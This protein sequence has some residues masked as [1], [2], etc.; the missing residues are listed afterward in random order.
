ME[1]AKQQLFRCGS[2]KDIYYCSKPCQLAD[3]KGGHKLEC[4]LY[5]EWVASMGNNTQN[6]DDLSLITRTMLALAKDDKEGCTLVEDW[7]GARFST[8]PAA[9]A[10]GAVPCP[11]SCGRAHWESMDSDV[12]IWESEEAEAETGQGVGEG[13]GQGQEDKAQRLRIATA[14]AD[15]LKGVRTVTPEEAVLAMK[16]FSAN[17]FSI[18]NEMLTGYAAGVFPWAAVLNH[19]CAPNCVV[20]FAFS[21]KPEPPLLQLIAAA[22]IRPGDELCH[23]YVDLTLATPNRGVQLKQ[24]YGIDRCMCMRCMGGALAPWPRAGKDTLSTHIDPF[25]F[26]GDGDGYGDGDGD[27]DGDVDA[28]VDVDGDVDGDGGDRARTRRKRPKV[29]LPIDDFYDIQPW[30]RDSAGKAPHATRSNAEVFAMLTKADQA[31]SADDDEGELAALKAALYKHD[32]A[33]LPPVGPLAYRISTRLL[34]ALIVLGMHGE[35]LEQCK[36]VVVCLCVALA[37]V[38]HHPLLGLQLFTLA[39]L[40]EAQGTS[41]GTASATRAYKW[42]RRVLAVTHGTHSALVRRLDSFL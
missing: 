27:G 7:N 22:D 28:D 1:T 6:F 41:A 16:R 18:F 21:N 26:C 2:C 20:R 38:E 19:S 17:N 25:F 30:A 11:V 3:W 31:L 32:A 4:G 40:F 42:A 14:A 35:A 39:D 34:S 29:F 33:G 23:S 36:R 24:K 13:Q 12:D 5:P 9:A 8:L 15:A 37:H 10:G